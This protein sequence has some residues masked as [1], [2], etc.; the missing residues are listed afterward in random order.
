LQSKPLSSSVILVVKEATDVKETFGIEE[1]TQV[2][3]FGGA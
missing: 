1:Q 3:L 2:H